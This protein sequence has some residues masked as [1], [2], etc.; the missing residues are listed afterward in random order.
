MMRKTTLPPTFDQYHGE[1]QFV[2]RDITYQRGVLLGEGRTAHVYRFDP[3]NPTLS[4]QSVAVKIEREVKQGGVDLFVEGS[5]LRADAHWNNQF[6]GLG[7]LSGA[8]WSTRQRHYVLMPYFAGVMAEIVSLQGARE[9][10][11][12]FI[13]VAS[14][15]HEKMHVEKKAIHGD[16]KPNNVIFQIT[17]KKVCVI[18]FGLT[19]MIG[20]QVGQY[21]LP[22]TRDP[23]WGVKTVS[24]AEA[25]PHNAPELFGKKRVSAQPSQDA[26]GLGYFLLSLLVRTNPVADEEK[27]KLFF[28]IAGLRAMRPTERLLIPAAIAQLHADFIVV[29][30]R[31]ISNKLVFFH[32]RR[33]EAN[34]RV[35]EGATA[36]SVVPLPLLTQAMANEL[37]G[38][39]E[40]LRGP[41]AQ[42]AQ[43]PDFYL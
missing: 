32:E 12:W 4:L 33:A 28:V 34:Q 40:L 16:I 20:E 19:D 43:L 17:E 24:S 41:R 11:E 6:Y 2:F 14:F 42:P 13:L 18:D 37:L 39:A 7:V 1:N 23:K 36:G 21:P 29:L 8:P 38:V 35:S 27:R 31:L 25:Y 30:P 26:Y 10:V 3:V 5:S 15:I 22:V 9:L